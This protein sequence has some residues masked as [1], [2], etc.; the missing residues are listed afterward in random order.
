[1]KLAILIPCYNEALTIEKVVQEVKK[2]FPE[3]A[4]HVYDNNSTDKTAEIAHANG[5]FVVQESRQGKGNVVRSMF[6]DI[7]ADVY[8]LI[9]GDNACS[10]ESIHDLIKPI[11]DGRADMV[12]GERMSNGTYS[13][14][15]TRAFHSLGNNLV[16]NLINFFFKSKLTDIMAGYR[17]FN[18]YYVKTFPVLSR[19][20]E[21]ETEMTIFA[22]HNNYKVT[23]VPLVFRNRPEGSV[24]KLN[25]FRDGLKVLKVILLFFK[26]LRPLLFFGSTSLLVAITGII[27]GIKPIIEFLNGG[28][29]YRVPS[30][31]LAAALEIIA[32]LL[33]ACGL[34]LDSA[35]SYQRALHEQNTILFK[36]MDKKN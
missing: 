15:N 20:F 13:K 16:K 7:D 14:E 36:V 19:G 22:L 35:V 27:V 34:I 6:K 31:I 26:D 8:V 30:A 5:A 33:F 32:L 10:A 21:I 3:A 28:F 17:A 11:I 23:E 2:E 29:V 1:M 12:I 18:R 4:V 24:S 9:D 25:T